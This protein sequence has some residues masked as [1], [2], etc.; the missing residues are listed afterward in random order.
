MD[1]ANDFIENN[2]HREKKTIFTQNLGG[3]K[4]AIKECSTR[5]TEAQYSVKE[6]EKMVKNDGYNYSDFFIL[7][8]ANY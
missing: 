8:R 3:H 4:P 2:R 6:I 5:Y 1:L 7:Y